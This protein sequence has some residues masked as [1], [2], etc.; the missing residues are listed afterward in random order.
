[1]SF[2]FSDKD[3]VSNLE[4]DYHG[5]VDLTENGRREAKKVEN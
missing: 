1:M 2:N 3:K 5:Y 4:K